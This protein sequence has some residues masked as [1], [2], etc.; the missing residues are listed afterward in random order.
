MIQLDKNINEL[1]A[2]EMYVVTKFQ[3][4]SVMDTQYS[5]KRLL[6]LQDFLMKVIIG[7]KN[8]SVFQILV[9]SEEKY[10]K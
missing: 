6:K 1:L 7:N 3:V 4:F 5:Q 2:S 9:K 10:L 8:S